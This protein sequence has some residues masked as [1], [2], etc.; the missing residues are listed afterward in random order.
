[1][2]HFKATA[3]ALLMSLGLFVLPLTMVSAARFSFDGGFVSEAGGQPKFFN[4]EEWYDR[5]QTVRV[6]RED[7]RT[8][9]IPYQDFKTALTNE[10]S[11]FTRDFTRSD[12]YLSL[13]G[14]WKFKAVDRPMDRI[15]NFWDPAGFDVGDWDDI[16]VPSSWQTI[17]N[18]D[19]SLK[20]DNPIYT[21]TN[22]PWGNFG[23]SVNLTNPVKAP[24]TFN[25]VGHYRRTFR[26][27][28]VWDGRRVFVSF[29]GVESA[30]YL[31]V[32]GRKVGYAEDSYT[33]SEFDITSYLGKG[34]NT[35]A[36]QV[37]RWSLGSYLENQD[38]IRFSGIFRDVFLFSKD[39]VE[40]RD[41]FVKP[42]LEDGFKK[43]FITL[44]ATVRNFGTKAGRYRVEATLKNMN[45]T[46]VWSSGPLVIPVA[47]EASR[48][49]PSSK[50]AIAA[51][52]V[53]APRLWFPET[54]ELY[55]LLIQL[56]APNG[57]IIETAV[58]RVG[59]R[60]IERVGVPGD[61]DHQMLLIN[62]KRLM[63]RGVCRHE[64][65]LV[66]GR[67][68]TKDEIIEDLL[69]M[70]RNNI[71]A[72]RTSHYPN[73]VLTYDLADEL[74]LYI[75]AEANVE[76]HEGADQEIAAN[77]IPG[78][79]PLWH[80][81]VMDRVI[82]SVERDKNHPAIIIWSLG[83]EATYREK[84]APPYT[85]YAFYS[86]SQY[87]RMRDPA[88][89][90]KYER[91]NREDIV[92]IRSE[93]YPGWIGARVN[94]I[95]TNPRDGSAVQFDN[96]LPY[97]MNEYS[98]SMGNAGGGFDEYW[99]LFRQVPQIQ[100]GF[101]WD[102]IDQSLWMPVPAHIRGVK[103]PGN[104]RYYAYGGDW[105]DT[106]NDGSFCANG[107]MFADRTPKPFLSEVRHV[108]QEIWYTS[109]RDDLKKGKI[110]IS[111]EFLN[112]N[113][114]AFG[115]RWRIKSNGEIIADGTLNI[116]I[117]PQEN[118]YV[119][120]SAVGSL[121]PIEGREYFLEIEAFLKANT[122]WAAAGHVI[123]SEQFRLPFGTVGTDLT[124]NTEALKPFADVN[125]NAE[126]ILLT[127]EDFSISFDKVRA[128]ITS[129]KKNGAELVSFGPRINHWRHPGDNDLRRGPSQYNSTFKAS[130][131]NSKVQSVYIR[132]DDNG[133]SVNISVAATL[134]NGASNNAVYTI[135]SNGHI[136]VKNTLASS[137]ENN[138]LR[139]GMKMEMAP[140]F[141]NV[142]YYGKGPFENYSD[143][144]TGCKVDVYKTT[145]EDMY[146]P[147]IR[148]QFF[149]N[150]TGVRWFS[151]TDQK[152]RG[153]LI[154]AETT[155][156]ACASHFDDS[157]FDD[158]GPIRHIYQAYKREGAILNIDM[159]QAPIGCWGGFTREV[160][161]VEKQISANGT[162]TYTFKIVPL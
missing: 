128:E 34:E 24:V 45:D 103:S 81:S 9:F 68:I 139:I 25:P 86:A 65:S 57:E 6:N 50:T 69:N 155:I 137:L 131:E 133:K 56:R 62:G 142:T 141:E 28:D 125:E 33:P 99:K 124:V 59:F 29:Q 55:K 39:T 16:P 100:G 32:N 71:N 3:T 123:A 158:N 88:R 78:T 67:A 35:I 129:I 90:I 53:A 76:S 51:K 21:N 97:L 106:I 49:G 156:E 122:N 14:L 42:S 146:T 130:W 116:S 7:A 114:N 75:C 80:N 13:N 61:P 73:N 161:P 145:V 136:I 132:K 70:K 118:D 108:M 48:G 4:G 19:G 26:L 140:G 37:Y 117:A 8:F 109:A 74:G 5:I 160:Q 153:L 66:N 77:R 85:N 63:V 112:K 52:V 30:F 91:D 89:M 143:R 119:T 157:E 121:L 154:N 43:G 101:I 1:M 113:L 115:H 58:A 159:V 150:R 79:N 135:Y 138:L 111:N 84:P 92:D 38:M 64:N 11:A 44:E 60:K 36:V 22:Y 46:N 151:V 126:R 162:Y 110:N 148:P 105:G 27:P 47:V 107:I 96:R 152:G 54:P 83:N 127:G 144:S 102:Y 149:G 120:I 134:K 20:Y 104:D 93:Q 10:H 98:H 2:A 23:G 17:R 94:A 31:W 40:L 72:I 41:F 12:Y 87:I 95:R 18:A 147:Y 82:S 15:D